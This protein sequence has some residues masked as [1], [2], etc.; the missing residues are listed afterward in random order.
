[1]FQTH[2]ESEAACM[3]PKQVFFL[4]ECG[5]LCNS[6]QTPSRPCVKCYLQS[7]MNGDVDS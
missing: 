2:M 6:A 7:W 3:V 4:I 1:M 5:Q